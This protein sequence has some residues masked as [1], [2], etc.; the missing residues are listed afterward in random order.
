ML[1]LRCCGLLVLLRL[2]IDFAITTIFGF[3]VAVSLALGRCCLHPVRGG[4]IQL[5]RATV[6]ST[7]ASGRLTGRA[8]HDADL[9]RRLL[10]LLLLM[11]LQVCLL[12]LVVWR[13]LALTLALAWVGRLA[14]LPIRSVMRAAVARGAGRGGGRPVPRLGAARGRTTLHQPLDIQF[15]I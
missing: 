7:G 14:I 4:V 13:G 8:A 3:S 11:L 1:L 10:L 15:I 5:A 12:L 9:R 6:G 2:S